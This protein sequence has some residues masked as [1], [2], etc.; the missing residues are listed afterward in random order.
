[1]APASARGISCNEELIMAEEEGDE[2]LSP[3]RHKRNKTLTNYTYNEDIN[4]KQSKLFGEIENLKT[5]LHTLM[6][7][8]EEEIPS[9]FANEFF[10]NSH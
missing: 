6:I 4:Q 7:E 5:E 8:G 9:Q 2:C 3:A 10:K 1:M